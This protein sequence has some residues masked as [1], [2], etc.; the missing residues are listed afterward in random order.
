MNKENIKINHKFK[1]YSRS[2][3]YGPLK[4]VFDEKQ[5]Y[6]VKA[7]TEILKNKIISEYSRCIFF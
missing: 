7:E 4:I 1:E 2:G 3:K 6:I 5:G